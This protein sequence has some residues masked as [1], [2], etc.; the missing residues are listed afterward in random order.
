MP[1]MKRIMN[2]RW[3]YSISSGIVPMRV[4][5]PVYVTGWGSSERDVAMNEFV[6][7][8][9]LAASAIALLALA[10]AYLGQSGRED[11]H[12]A[13]LQ[14]AAEATLPAGRE[15][16]SPQASERTIASS[17]ELEPLH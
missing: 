12:Y 13:S 6:I 17:R 8:A 11:A 16:A 9:A 14:P 7:R 4:V 3:N 15:Q 10:A 1:L 2:I 5:G